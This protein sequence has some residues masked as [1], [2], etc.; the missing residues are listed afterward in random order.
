MFI[1]PVDQL[2]EYFHLNMKPSK[3]MNTGCLFG[4]VHNLVLLLSFLSIFLNAM[5]NRLSRNVTVVY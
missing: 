4:Y 1:Q 2:G 3:S 5:A